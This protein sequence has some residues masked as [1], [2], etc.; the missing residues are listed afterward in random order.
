MLKILGIIAIV[1]ICLWILSM[2]VYFFNLDMKLTSALQP[3][4][5]KHYDKIKKDR[6][7]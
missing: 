7:I 1:L 3:L 2:I 4:L 6:K 5:A